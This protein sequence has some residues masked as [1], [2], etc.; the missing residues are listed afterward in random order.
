MSEKSLEG[1]R[2]AVLAADGFE[3]VEV[4]R[5]MKAL[6]K[7]GA[8]VEIVSLRPGSI[9]GMNLLEPGK[10]LDVDRTLLTAKADDYH[11][12]HIPGGFVNPDFLRQSEEALDFVTEFDR[13][14]KPISVICH[15]AWVLISAELVKGR[16]LTSWPG[17]KDDVRNAGGV[18]VDEAVVHDTNWVSSRGPEDISAFEEA[19]VAH[20]AE[21]A[22]RA[23]ET[24]AGERAWGRWIAGGAAV[25]AASYA[26]REA[27]RSRRTDGGAWREELTASEQAAFGGEMA[28][29]VSGVGQPHAASGM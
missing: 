27:W 13:L 18:W 12:L 25:A 24:A 1:L 5:P 6:R 20:F 14:G 22:G 11:G 7:H 28:T 4:T 21:H 26:A 23:T 29:E 16:R 2:I 17:I 19:I 9:R 15:G 10:K 3:Q 8:E